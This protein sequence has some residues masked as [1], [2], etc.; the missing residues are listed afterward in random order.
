MDKIFGL[1]EQALKLSEDRSVMLSNNLVN[2]STP[3]YKAKDIDFHQA[4]QE[5]NQAYGLTKPMVHT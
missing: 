4:L 2:S 5:A 3:H 1:S